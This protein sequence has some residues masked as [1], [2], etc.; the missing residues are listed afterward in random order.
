MY[1]SIV[2]LPFP[3]QMS[4]VLDIDDAMP[5]SSKAVCAPNWSS[6]VIC[7]EPFTIA[8]IAYGDVNRSIGYNTTLE[9]WM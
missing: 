1:R 3:K 4:G 9:Y 7:S 2:S 5:E 8:T 6:F